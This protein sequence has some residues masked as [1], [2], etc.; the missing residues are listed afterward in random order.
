MSASPLPGREQPSGT[1]AHEQSL[2]HD[3]DRI[4]QLID[5]LRVVGGAPVEQRVQELVGRLV[6]LYGAA[7][8]R[9]LRMAQEGSLGEASGEQG[10]HQRLLA[11][12]L[13]SSLLVLHG[14][15]PA[16]EAAQA[17]DPGPAPSAHGGGA[18]NLVQIDLGRSHAS[19]SEGDAP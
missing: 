10:L 13:L 15:H 7:L 18:E 2:R 17:F 1:D 5:E 19:K 12:P 14:I 8:E 4:A 6:G 9:L 11:D 3:G 16:P